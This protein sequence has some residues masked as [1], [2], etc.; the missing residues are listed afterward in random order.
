MDRLSRQERYEFVRDWTTV[1]RRWRRRLDERLKPLNMSQA[2]WTVLYFLGQATEVVNQ[3]A[4]AD[5][6]AVEPPTLVRVLDQL[7]KQGLLERQVSPD[8]RR[9]NLLRLTEAAQPVL[10]R[11]ETIAEALR[12]ELMGDMTYEEYET[13]MKVIRRFRERLG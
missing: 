4:L 9:V 13:D 2:R 8:D 7:E 1:G 6:I 11:I 3:S 10:A 5:L 12:I